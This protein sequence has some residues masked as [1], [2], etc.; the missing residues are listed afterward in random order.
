[1]TKGSQTIFLA[2]DEQP[3]ERRR[4]GTWTPESPLPLPIRPR[5]ECSDGYVLLKYS[6]GVSARQCIDLAYFAVYIVWGDLVDP[7]CRGVLICRVVLCSSTLEMHDSFSLIVCDCITS[8]PLFRSF[9]ELSLLGLA[10]VL[11]SS[12]LSLLL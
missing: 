10:S 3:P 9:N 1:M 8:C 4:H 11:T 2:G 12:I 6:C 5:G 7:C